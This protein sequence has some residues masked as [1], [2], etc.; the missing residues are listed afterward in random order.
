MAYRTLKARVLHWLARSL[1]RASDALLRRATSATSAGPPPPRSASSYSFDGSAEGASG[2]PADW[3]EEVRRVVPGYVPPP[4]AAPLSPM[5]AESSPAVTAPTEPVPPAPLSR[6]EQRRTVLPLR[7]AADTSVSWT[8]L[9]SAPAHPVLPDVRAVASP[10]QAM[11]PL[12]LRAVVPEESPAA[13]AVPL[14]GTP[15]TSQRRDPAWRVLEAAAGEVP[16]APPIAG[17]SPEAQQPG[18]VP[19]D[20][21]PGREAAPDVV[22]LEVPRP[23]PVVAS[24]EGPP[25]PSPAAQWSPIGAQP[26]PVAAEAFPRLDVVLPPRPPREARPSQT[27]ADHWPS[28][29]R[30]PPTSCAQ[31]V[32]DILRDRQ[33]TARLKS[34]QAGRPWSV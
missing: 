8:A 26:T 18:I 17:S 29:P 16:T 7:E 25:R 20:A 32:A 12:K 15:A 10:A 24:L 23:S 19:P 21:V 34:E 6:T 22:P 31:E 3:V 5:A 13:P 4:P 27:P 28:L 1:Q 9:P 33:S 11:P 14:R 2:P 30:F